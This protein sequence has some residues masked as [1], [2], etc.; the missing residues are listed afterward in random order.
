MSTYQNTANSA[1]ISS[2]PTVSRA[3]KKSNGV[4]VSCRN[5]AAAATS[6]ERMVSLAEY[7]RF[8]AKK[9]LQ[10][11]SVTMNGGSLK[12]ATRAP[13]IAPHSAP[14]ARPRRK[15]TGTGTPTCTASL[16]IT[17]DDRTMIAPTDRS[18]PA[19]STISVCARPTMP[20]MV[21]CWRTSDRLKADRK[22]PP[23]RRLKKAMPISSTMAGIAVG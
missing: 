5:P 16:P 22:R 2:E 8:N 4:P 21:T 1:T 15:A 10:V 6:W 17:T 12:Y 14:T 13:L 3:P 18:M 19:V 20:M 7:Q 9:M 11:P 23:T